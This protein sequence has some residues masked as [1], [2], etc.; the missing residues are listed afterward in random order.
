MALS[1]ALHNNELKKL[2]SAAAFSDLKCAPRPSR[3]IKGSTSRGG[4]EKK[5]IEK[6]GR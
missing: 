6:G 4:E 1:F 2:L 5:G 3:W